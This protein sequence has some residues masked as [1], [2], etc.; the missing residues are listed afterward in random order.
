MVNDETRAAAERLTGNCWNS[1]L[2]DPP[3]NWQEIFEN[4]LADGRTVATEL[5]R[6]RAEVAE[7]EAWKRGALSVMKEMDT[8]AVGKLLGVPL[9]QPIYAAIEPGIRRLMEEN[10]ELVGLMKE[11]LMFTQHG[12]YTVN[13]SLVGGL[14]P[15]INL[16]LL[17]RINAALARHDAGK[18]G[19]E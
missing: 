2:G 1:Y 8:Q 5:D 7:L 12:V 18:G 6:L 11:S 15:Q 10:A 16:E 3:R 13:A 9:G 19:G 17:G 14:Y 4:L